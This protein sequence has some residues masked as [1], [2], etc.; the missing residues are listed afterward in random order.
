MEQLNLGVQAIHTGP[1]IRREEIYK[2]LGI[3]K[4]LK[5]FNIFLH[6][7]RKVGIK[8]K[9]IIIDKKHKNSLDMNNSISKQLSS[10]LKENLN[11][12]QNFDKIIIYYDNG[13]YQLANIL[14]SVFSSW[15]HDKFEYRTV[16]PYEYRLFQVADFI[17]TLALIDN[18]LKNGQNLT[19]SEKL[20]FNNARLFRKNY[21]KKVEKLEF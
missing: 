21:M 12:F 10:F 11:Y 14:I 2:N 3:E 6:F 20:L 19:K 15:F 4:R 1:L 9:N 17:C 7:T 16:S 5:I 8:Y 13:Q 18:K